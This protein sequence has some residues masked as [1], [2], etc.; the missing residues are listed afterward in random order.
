MTR[1]VPNMQAALVDKLGKLVSPWNSWFQQFTQP[2]LA[3][4]AV[5]VGA[6]PFLYTPNNIGQVVVSGGT[7]SDISL[8]RG[9]VTISLFTSTAFPRLILVSIGD[10]I[11]VTYSVLPTIRFMEL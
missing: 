4:A 2:P 6:S 10:T 9:G 3:V 7:V 1:P 8:I 11:Q 5:A